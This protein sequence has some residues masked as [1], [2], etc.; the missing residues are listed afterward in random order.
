MIKKGFPI[1]NDATED[2]V[3]GKIL[4]TFINSPPPMEALYLTT[5]RGTGTV[6][7]LLSLG[8]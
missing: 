8:T 7:F 1:P 3:V 2:I 6:T 5:A 4:I